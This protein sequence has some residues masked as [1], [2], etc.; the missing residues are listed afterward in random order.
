MA[1][2]VGALIGI[3]MLVERVGIAMGL[4][5]RREKFLMSVNAA[6]QSEAAATT[7]TRLHVE[8]ITPS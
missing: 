4:S 6:W 1:H 2:R 7:S 3:N 8:R 5:V